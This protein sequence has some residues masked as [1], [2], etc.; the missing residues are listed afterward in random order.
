MTGGADRRPPMRRLIAL[1]LRKVL[2]VRS[3]AL[4][5]GLVILLV[6]A[7]VAVRL[8]GGTAAPT[9]DA[10]LVAA[11]AP[12]AVLLPV[13][14]ILSITS[15]WS[16]RTALVTFA[17]V[18]D[19][20]RVIGAKLLAAV[21]LA[22]AGAAVTLGAATAGFAVAGDRA[23][24]GWHLS[25]AGALQLALLDEVDMLFG[26]AFGLLVLASGPAIVTFYVVPNSWNLLVALLPGVHV[27]GWVSM[28][29]AAGILAQPTVEGR[30]WAQV[31]C[32]CAVWVLAPG[33]AGAVRAGRAEIP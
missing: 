23:R 31:A 24:G 29:R 28:S 17:L 11:Q 5:A 12:V 13:L 6:V 20:R 3:G 26:C 4:P 16:Q 33:I 22:A 10:L 9:L 8:Q 19:R 21:V 30:Q 32:A 14:G 2:D 18:P 1:E 15:E 7:V 27:L 25:V